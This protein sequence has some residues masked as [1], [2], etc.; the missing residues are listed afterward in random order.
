MPLPSSYP[1]SNSIIRSATMRDVSLVIGF[2]ALAIGIAGLAGWAFSIEFL[3]S[4]G[5]HWATMKGNTALALA[6][7][8][9]SLCLARSSRNRL[10]TVLAVLGAL[11]ALA[12]GSANL[13]ENIFDVEFGI[14][15]LIFPDPV[16][17]A[18]GLPP[19]RQ[20]PITAL[21]FILLAVALL[22]L[23]SKRA[24]VN[25]AA[26]LLVIAPLVFSY[27]AILGYV[28][29]E[30]GL[31]QVPG[32][33][34]FSLP[35]AVGQSL[36]GLG[37]LAASPE[38]G[39]TRMFLSKHAG[40]RLARR[41]VPF[42]L[43]ALPIVGWLRLEAQAL[44]LLN[45]ETGVA[46]LLAICLVAILS[47]ILLHTNALERAELEQQRLG[48]AITASRVSEA[49]LRGILDAA[50]DAMVIANRTGEIVMA[51]A[52]AKHLFGYTR[53][54]L[55]GQPVELL[56]PM[57]L[58]NR[59]VE[60]RKEYWRHPISRPMGRGLMLTGR[61]KDSTEIPVEIGLS[62]LRTETG[63]FVISSIRDITERVGLLEALREKNIAL[64]QASRAKDRFLATVSHELRTP[65]TVIIG[66]AGTLLMKVVGT[67]N[68][69]QET[70]LS[71]IRSSAEHL[72]SLIND[73]LD[74]SK[75]EAGQLALNFAPT[76]IQAVIDEVGASMRP[77]AES[78][79]ISLETDL[80]AAPK[81]IRTDRRALT[82]ILLNLVN[83]GI[84]F[85]EQGSVRIAV[86][87]VKEKGRSEIRLRVADTGIGIR[88]EDQSKLF[89]AFTQ[90]ENGLQNT[91]TGLGLHLSRELAIRLG[92]DLSCESAL[93]GGS[94]F[95]LTL[96]EH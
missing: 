9:M 62:P 42:S 31:Y 45:L 70:Q 84:K 67:L 40:G 86:D 32:F 4:F 77:L 44:G 35:S 19:G 63:E 74:V 20:A 71:R 28:L 5:P 66:Y 24:G 36:L 57:H 37:I 96:H 8:G 1:D 49:S 54:E 22:M 80:S 55:V 87:E 61:R 81:L 13:V 69:Q 16:S 92:G 11:L 94:T 79:G 6:S 18:Q 82:Q 76:P 21:N 27:T 33:S 48:A 39:I 91:G 90:L 29:A 34:S 26:Q 89:K 58:R 60:N 12:I 52:A 2:L 65:L 56:M 68:P 50:P 7:A 10:G 43:V 41:V 25:S 15:Q 46:F 38:T 51:N 85:T 73:I 59:H 53:E 17:A 3:K 75:I 78:K 30:S 93:G 23:R 83:N 64:E 14:D 72:L 88:P 47:V 95:T